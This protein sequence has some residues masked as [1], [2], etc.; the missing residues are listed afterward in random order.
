VAQPAALLDRDRVGDD[1]LKPQNVLVKRACLVEIQRR[2]ANVGNA[3]VVH[4][5]APAL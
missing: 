4:G 1:W 3:S 5:F 2:Q